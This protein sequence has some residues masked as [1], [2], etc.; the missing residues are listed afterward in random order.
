MST[1]SA[2]GAPTDRDEVLSP[3]WLGHALGPYLGGEEIMAVTVVEEQRTLA[4][5][6]RCRLDF[7]SEASDLPRHICI[8]GFFGTESAGRV[9]IGEPEALFYSELA[10]TLQLRMP[11]CLYAAVDPA[12]RHGLVIMNDLLVEGVEF[13]TALSPY[14]PTQVADTL[15]QLAALH[16]QTW[17]DPRLSAAWL[18]PQVSSFTDYITVDLLQQLLDGERGD[19]LPDA[20]RRADRLQAGVRAVF[21]TTAGERR[22]LVH[23]DAHA[24]NLYLDAVGAPG[25]LDW[26]IVRRGHWSFDV[27]YHL[28]AALDVADRRSHE[29]SLVRDYVARMR[30]AGVELPD[31]DEAWRCYQRAHVYGY[32]L[33]AVTRTVDPRIT[34]EFVRRLGSAVADHESLDQL[35]V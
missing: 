26:Q 22:C 13:L 14:T 17:D 7:A 30:S 31:W 25:L 15:G 23:G 20:V 35:G 1:A 2:A 29:Q 27:A 24:G 28:A 19:P 18:E 32:N 8:K 10:P 4:T 9:W 34:N 16:A 6:L 12:N 21:A 11:R 33:W 3:A 5:K